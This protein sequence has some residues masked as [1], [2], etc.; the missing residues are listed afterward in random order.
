M[1]ENGSARCPMAGF[2]VSGAELSGS[3]SC[4]VAQETSVV[5]KKGV[6][7]SAG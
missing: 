1:N 2:G 7:F 3:A 4:D 6:A 5:T